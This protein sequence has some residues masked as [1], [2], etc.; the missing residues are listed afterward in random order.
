MLALFMLIPLVVR[1]IFQYT[2]N[3]G[4]VKT[5]F[6]INDALEAELILLDPTEEAQCSLL[7][8]TIQFQEETIH[9]LS[10]Y[11]D[12]NTDDLL[13]DMITLNDETQIGLTANSNLFYF[14]NS[15]NTTTLYKLSINIDQEILP[16]LL[17]SPQQLIIIYPKIAYS[18]D[19]QQ[20]SEWKLVP[21]LQGRTNRYYS[22]IINS[23]L[24]SAVGSDGLDIYR[25]LTLL[26]TIDTGS[27]GLQNIDFRDFAVYQLN[28]RK[29]L[30]FILCKING[31]VV[32]ELSFLREQIAFKLLLKQIGPKSDGIVID[33]WDESNV[34]VAYK[35]NHYYY[36]V[37]YN[38]EPYNKKWSSI[39]KY[40]I[41]NR[42]IDIDVN[43]NY[44]LVQGTYNHHFIQYKKQ[45]SSVSFHLGAVK[46]FVSSQNYIY[47]TTSNY[48]FKFRPLIQPYSI[49]CYIESDQQF[50]RQKYKLLY[51]TQLNWQSTE[52]EVLF[53][54]MPFSIST[55]LIILIIILSIIVLLGILAAY[56]Y[57][58][59]Q[60]RNNEKLNLEQR[61]QYLPQ[62][63]ASKLLMPHTFRTIQQHVEQK[64]NTMNFTDETMYPKDKRIF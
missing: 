7:S 2:V 1:A 43:E 29:F 10:E 11:T 60:N 49:K 62:N 59:Y 41:S 3:Y 63:R 48:L 30:I 13:I 64:M 61:I 55:N 58:Q 18:A 24:I 21:T 40:N 56:Q 42:I 8:P 23:Y 22:K 27:V 52:F 26:N 4:E 50:I 35:N 6:N 44:V 38:I 25:N 28:D 47:G 34:F 5:L 46:Q 39:A 31:V 57:K 20:G 33:I 15:T 51:K 37:H 36:L 19:T 53:N 9:R 16:Q 32:V 45:Q 14:Y 12:L 17:Y 54:Q